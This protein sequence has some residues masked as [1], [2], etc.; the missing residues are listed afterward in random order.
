[1]PSIPGSS[2][3]TDTGVKHIITGIALPRKADVCSANEPDM[4]RTCILCIRY[5]ARG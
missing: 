4:V 2:P 3:L 1:M 5:T